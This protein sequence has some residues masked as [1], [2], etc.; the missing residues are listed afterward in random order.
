VRHVKPVKSAILSAAVI[1]IILVPSMV[2]VD[3]HHDDLRS[4]ISIMPPSFARYT[5]ENS[6]ITDSDGNVLF[7]YSYTKDKLAMPQSEGRMMFADGDDI[8][9]IFTVEYAYGSSNTYQIAIDKKT[10]LPGEV[11]FTGEKTVKYGIG[12]EY[13]SDCGEY[14]YKTGSSNFTIYQDKSS[15]IIVRF[16]MN[17]EGPLA[18]PGGTVS[19][20]SAEISAKL[21]I[22]GPI[23]RG[24]DWNNETEIPYF[25]AK[26]TITTGTPEPLTETACEYEFG[27]PQTSS[28]V[29]FYVKNERVYRSLDIRNGEITEALGKTVLPYAFEGTLMDC[30]P[31]KEEGAFVRI[32]N[33][34][35]SSGDG[36]TYSTVT[37]NVT[38]YTEYISEKEEG[39]IIKMTTSGTVRSYTFNEDGTLQEQKYVSWDLEWD[40]P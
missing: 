28:V 17:Y 23:R 24:A 19:M 12:N 21:D 29:F 30:N 35:I 18:V 15:G 1:L 4:E 37:S 27:F 26:G 11:S 8:F 16:E 6:R 5:T 9:T 36:F 33:Y 3:S 10:G 34:S 39:K 22:N 20:V 25:G 13:S 14:S 32:A 31:Q 40:A 38:Q 7:S 2:A